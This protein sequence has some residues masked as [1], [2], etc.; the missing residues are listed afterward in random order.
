MLLQK[1]QTKNY[2][3]YLL[4]LLYIDRFHN[5]LLIPTTSPRRCASYAREGA[6]VT[7]HDALISDNFIARGSMV[8]IVSSFIH[9]YQV[10]FIDNTESADVS[11]VQLDDDST[12]VA[13]ETTFTGFQGEVRRYVGKS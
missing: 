2:P 12:F 11:A 7:I 13:E 8:F 4:T 3:T 9:T 1:V 5:L 6:N 10:K